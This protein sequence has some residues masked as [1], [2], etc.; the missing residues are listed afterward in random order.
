MICWVEMNALGALTLL[1]GVTRRGVACWIE[2]QGVEATPGAECGP[3]TMLP[4]STLLL[5]PAVMRSCDE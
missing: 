2:K 1:T 3:G 4:E 5:L